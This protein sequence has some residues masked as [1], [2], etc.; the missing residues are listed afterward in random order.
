MQGNYDSAEPNDSAFEAYKIKEGELSGASLHVENDQDWY[1]WDATAEFKSAKFIVSSGYDVEVYTA[2]GNKLKLNPQ[3]PDYP[4]G[5]HFRF[6]DRLSPYIGIVSRSGYPVKNHPVTLY[7]ESGAWNEQTGNK[8]RTVTGK[9][10]KEGVVKL[11]LEK[12]D[13]PTSLGSHSVYLPG[14]I[15]FTHYYD[16]DGIVISSPGVEAYPDV[17]YHFAYSV[18]EGN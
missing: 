5:E 11:V 9:T 4:E 18:Y 10:N 8:T 16:I 3:N 13:L 15:Q 14:P 1:I 2:D 6:K 17:V 12:P 7:W